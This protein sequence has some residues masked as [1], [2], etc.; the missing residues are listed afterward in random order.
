[1]IFDSAAPFDCADVRELI[2]SL[3]VFHISCLKIFHIEPF[4]ETEFLDDSHLYSCRQNDQS[5]LLIQYVKTWSNIKYSKIVPVIWLHQLIMG[6]IISLE[7]Q[8]KILKIYNIN[9]QGKLK[10]IIDPVFLKI[11]KKFKIKKETIYG[12]LRKNW[13]QILQ[14]EPYVKLINLHQA[15]IVS[16]LK[17]RAIYEKIS[18]VMEYS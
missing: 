2:L 4:N 14:L 13:R 15:N 1:M 18:A 6:R 9:T 7:T 16:I 3:F 17:C 10:S 5:V 12:I 8:L 11:S